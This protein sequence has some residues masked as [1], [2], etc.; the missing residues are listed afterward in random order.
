MLHYR[1]L[2]SYTPKTA[3]ERFY[4]TTELAEEFF[5]ATLPLPSI[6]SEDAATHAAADLTHTLLNPNLVSP[7]T[8]LGDK[9]TAALNI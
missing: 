9:Q 4:D 7:I 8:T 3:K 1:C 5:P 2:T 6:S